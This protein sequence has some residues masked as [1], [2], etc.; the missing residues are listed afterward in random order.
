[1][2]GAVSFVKKVFR[3]IVRFVKK[4]VKKVIKT[5]KRVVKKVVGFAKKVY[6][7]Y[8][9][10]W[11]GPVINFAK[12]WIPGI[13]VISK[14]YQVIKSG[15]KTIKNGYKAFRNYL[16]NKPYKK[17]WNK[18]K[19]YGKKFIKSVGKSIR[20]S[21]VLGKVYNFGKKI[22]NYGKKIYDAGKKIYDT[23][24]R[25][26][27]KISNTFNFIRNSF[28][29]IKNRNNKKE[30][31]KYL[32]KMKNNWKSSFLSKF[33]YKKYINENYYNKINNIFVTAKKRE[34]INSFNKATSSFKR[35]FKPVI[36]FVNKR[37]AIIKRVVKNIYNKFVGISKSIFNKYETI[38]KPRYNI[39]YIKS[40]ISEFNNIKYKCQNFKESL[41]KMIDKKNE[42]INKAKENENF[43]YQVDFFKVFNVEKPCNYCR[44][45]SNYCCQ[46]CSSFNQNGDSLCIHFDNNGNCPICPQKCHRSWHIKTF[47]RRE[48]CN[49]TKIF[50][51]KKEVYDK[52]VNEIKNLE[53]EFNSKIKDVNEFMNKIKRSE[54]EIT[55]LICQLENNFYNSSNKYFN[56]LDTEIKNIINLGKN[57]W[58]SI[59][60]DELYNLK[61]EFE[62]KIFQVKNY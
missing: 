59:I 16:N 48:I 38:W 4:V 12:K 46:K 3:P 33:T 57:T 17:Y 50:K 35:L 30:A 61:S 18:A 47:S 21:T 55:K 56:L 28:N 5:V 8:I 51:E 15:I 53:N 31:K 32:S 23:G 27:K 10:P 44:K 36:T 25:I 52:Y 2:G 7:R 40:K 24:K 54:N 37:I 6:K 49:V 9:K 62:N 29:Y 45:C 14:G 39:Y 22:Y 1:M 11:A 58:A 60:V 13:S 42:Y 41:R 34:L 20:N 43:T 19:T 26:Y